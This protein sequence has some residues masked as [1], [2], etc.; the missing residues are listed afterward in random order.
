MLT[1]QA[2][3]NIIKTIPAEVGGEDRRA[4]YATV[5]GVKDGKSVKEISHY[6]SVDID[7][8]NK[9]IEFFNLDNTTVKKDVKRGR[10]SKD[11]ISYVKSNIGKTVTPKDVANELGI[12]LPTFY[13]FLNANRGFFK[14]VKRG[15]FQIINPDDIRNSEK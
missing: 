11:L 4:A 2:A 10:K 15:E 8:V 13:N 3:E 5:T 14:K 7:L 12:S 1:H 9:W 6:Y